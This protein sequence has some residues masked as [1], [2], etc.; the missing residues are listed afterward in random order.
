MKRGST[1]RTNVVPKRRDIVMVDFTPS[2]GKETPGQHPAVVMTPQAVNYDGFIVVC[3]ISSQAFDD[4][5]VF[6]APERKL[7]IDGFIHYRQVRALD[8]RA[9]NA[10]VVARC[11]DDCFADL[12]SRMLALLD[13]DLAGD[14]D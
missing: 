9:R 4:Y 13:P 1:P 14:R 12:V 5:T 2:A 3:H 7:G 10:R 11:P 6:L 8:F